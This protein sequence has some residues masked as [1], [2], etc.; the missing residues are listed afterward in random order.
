M[1][2]AME[3]R[4]L[5]H[6]TA[7]EVPICLLFKSWESAYPKMG[8]EESLTLVKETRN[9]F[10]SCFCP[11][12]WWELSRQLAAGDIELCALPAGDS[13]GRDMGRS[14]DLQS[15]VTMYDVQLS[16]APTS[17]PHFTDDRKGRKKVSW[18]NT[19]TC[20]PPKSLSLLMR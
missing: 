1:P 10:H 2:P 15:A 14:I 4:C 5:N 8:L 6:W 12:C 19:D 11:G 13:T 16:M 20:F 7:K 18:K 3:V 9:W 17:P